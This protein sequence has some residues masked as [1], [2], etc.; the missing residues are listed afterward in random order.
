LTA[1]IVAAEMTASM[2]GA[3][4]PPTRM[5]RRFGDPHVPGVWWPSAALSNS[6]INLSPPLRIA[7]FSPAASV[8]FLREAGLSMQ[9]TTAAHACASWLDELSPDEK[10]RYIQAL[11][12]HFA[13]HSEEVPPF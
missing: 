3:G 6:R 4:P 12:D 1:S 13:E 8:T 5:P 11:W 9:A 10:L 7:F 2:P